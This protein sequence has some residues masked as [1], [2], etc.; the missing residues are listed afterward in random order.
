MPRS[1]REFLSAQ[2]R[3]LWWALLGAALLR[4]WIGWHNPAVQTITVSPYRE[5]AVKLFETG[6]LSFDGIHP[7]AFRLPGYSLVMDAL[8]LITRRPDDV[9]QLIALNMGLM[10]A[11][12]LLT[13]SFARR[14]ASGAAASAAAV[15]LALN[16]HMAALNFSL[17]I[18]T[19]YLL[20]L[21]LIAWTLV[22]LAEDPDRPARWALAGAAI[23]VSLTVRSTFLVFPF[24]LGAGWFLLHPKRPR[25]RDLALLMVCAYAFVAPWTLR[26]YAHFGRVIPFEDGMGWHT[27]WQGSLSVEG[28]APDE[29]LPEPMRTYYFSSDPKIGP[30]SKK[31][32]LENIKADPLRYASFCLGRLPILW[33]KNG[34]PEILFNTTA[35]FREYRARGDWLRAGTKAA[36]KLLELLFLAGAVWGALLGLRSPR[37]MP[38]SL[39]LAYMNINI[40]TM[41]LPRYT[42]PIL[43]V[44]CLFFALAAADA[45]KR[46][47]GGNA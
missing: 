39:M 19:I 20:N 5:M 34:W 13:V 6:I 24:L 21:S 15:L 2:P 47:S 7:T 41:G 37:L 36:F 9:G 40:F 46:L 14:A 12:I 42:T 29:N 30:Y 11:S 17:G 10:A 4:A 1:A 35:S 8:F 18:E 32:A 43:P 28:I 3:G 25:A 38:L 44:M 23:G 16:P 33:L 22:R 27:L 45:R 26:N 31:L